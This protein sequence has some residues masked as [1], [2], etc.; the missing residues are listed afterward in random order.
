MD[1]TERVV[2]KGKVLKLYNSGCR[3]I[4]QGSTKEICPVCNCDF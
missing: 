2:M 1:K 3:N 4:K